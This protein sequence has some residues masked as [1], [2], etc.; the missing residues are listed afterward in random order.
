MSKTVEKQTLS[1]HSRLPPDFPI[2]RARNPVLWSATTH[3]RVRGLQQSPR[4][5]KNAEDGEPTS[6]RLS[7][8]TREIILYRM[9]RCENLM[10]FDSFHLF[11][12]GS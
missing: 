2:Q 5:P 3:R 12:Q 9:F 7:K 6:R 10:Y 11:H 1:Q 8:K 4:D